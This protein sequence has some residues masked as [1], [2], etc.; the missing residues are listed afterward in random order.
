MLYSP[1]SIQPAKAVRAAAVNSIWVIFSWISE[2]R[3]KRARRLV[4]RDLLRFDAALLDDLGIGRQN[5]VEAFDDGP[6]A[7]AY[8]FDLRRTRR[9]TS[10]RPPR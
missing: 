8:A 1:P 2:W 7:A 4:L 10:W 6:F 9:A 3:R 5:V